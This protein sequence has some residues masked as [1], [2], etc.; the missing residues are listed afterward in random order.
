MEFDKIED[1]MIVQNDKNVL[2]EFSENKTPV[3]NTKVAEFIFN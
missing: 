2:S 3:I 1:D